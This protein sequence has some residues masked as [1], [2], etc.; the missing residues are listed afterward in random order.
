MIP[1]KT[2]FYITVTAFVFTLI[3]CA[4]DDA[5]NPNSPI[6]PSTD[7]RDA[8][9][10]TWNVSENSTTST[11][12]NTYVVTIAKHGSNSS[13]VV[14]DN[15][16]GLNTYTVSATVSG[17]SFVIPYQSI[18]NN[19]NSTIGFA[20]GSGTLSTSTK[21]NIT[22]TTSISGNRDSCQTVYTK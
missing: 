4:K 20:S 15:F 1:M 6:T 11:T 7:S 3:S 19:T 18:K 8:L 9:V 12:P 5:N 21:I 2:L 13:A 10:G 22:Y 16:Y 17:S 14:I